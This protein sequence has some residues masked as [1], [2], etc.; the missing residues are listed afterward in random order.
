MIM[1]T[2]KNRNGM[3]A[4]WLAPALLLLGLAGCFG[5]ENSD[6]KEWM[7]KSSEGLEGKIEPLPEIKP[8]E[9]FTYAA[10][11]LADPFKPSKMEVVRRGGRGS[12]MPDFSR[13]RG[14]LEVYDLERLRMVGTLQQGRNIQGLVHAPDGNLYRVS[15]GGFIGQNFGQVVAI[16]ETEIRLKEIVEDLTGD[17]IERE[18]T[19]NLEEARQKTERKQ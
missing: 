14:P 18:A 4:C 9:P 15:V 8:Y 7:H 19:L 10:H 5:E 3:R 17:W 2:M 6:L 1:D 13:P 12:L 16:T 11:D